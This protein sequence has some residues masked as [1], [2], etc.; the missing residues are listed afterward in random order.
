MD[1]RDCYEPKGH[2]GITPNRR[3][4][5]TEGEEVK[6]VQGEDNTEMMEMIAQLIRQSTEEMQEQNRKAY[7]AIMDRIEKNKRLHQQNK[8]DN[9]EAI[10]LMKE[11]KKKTKIEMANMMNHSFKEWKEEI[12]KAI[13]RK[14]DE[15]TER[16]GER[17]TT[18]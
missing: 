2:V 14:N 17:L 4:K 9:R 1:P 15:I 6:Q 13:R 5:E 16:W 18:E 7:E 12:E 8:M 11:W 10:Q 3:W